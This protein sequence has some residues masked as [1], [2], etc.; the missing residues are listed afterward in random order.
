MSDIVVNKIHKS[1]GGRKVLEEF[2]CVF[3]EGRITAVTGKSGC[4]KTT[5]TNIVM[6]LIKPDSGTVLNVPAKISAVFQEDRLC[7]DFGAVSNIHFV[8]GRNYPKDEIE[9]CLL[10]LGLGGSLYKPVRELSG[11]MRRRVAIARALLFD[12]D[13][14]ILDEPFK[15]LDA[16]TKENVMGYIKQNAAGKTVILVTHNMDEACYFEADTVEMK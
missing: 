15:E 5:L 6:G 8:T 4:G 11:G 16:V 1:F 12:Y 14:L 7:E 13:L 9:K 10:Y 2:S 3:R